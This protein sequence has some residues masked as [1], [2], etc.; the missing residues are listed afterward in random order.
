MPNV[1]SLNLE[2]RMHTAPLAFAPLD[3]NALCYS[4]DFRREWLVPICLFKGLSL[5]RCWVRVISH[6]MAETV[7]E[8]ESW[9][10]RKQLIG[11]RWNEGKEA[12]NDAFGFERSRKG[13]KVLRIGC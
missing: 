2:F 10:L 8:V 13:I 1:R 5:D 6:V 3:L 12:R 11:E 9:K 7:L 4:G